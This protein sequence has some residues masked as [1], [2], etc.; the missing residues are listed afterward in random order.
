MI[1]INLI[2]IELKN[3]MPEEGADLLFEYRGKINHPHSLAETFMYEQG[4]KDGFV[5]R[6][7]PSALNGKH[8]FKIGVFAFFLDFT[9]YSAVI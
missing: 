5:L 2:F 3:M 7:M 1:G 6:K 8:T 9:G 4:L